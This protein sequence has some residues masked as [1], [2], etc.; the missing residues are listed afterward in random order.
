MILPFSSTII[1]D[2][3]A[4]CKSRQASIVYFYFDFRDAK[5][6]RLNDLISSIITQLSAHPDLRC[7]ILLRLY[8]DHD[9]GQRQPSDMDMTKCLKEMLILPH[10]PPIY[11]IIDAL[12]ESPDLSGIPT[13]REQVLDLVKELVDLCLPNLHICVTSRPEI[14][15]RRVIEPLT[16]L[17]VCLHEQSGQK[18]DIEEYIRS[19]VYSE[20][21]PIMRQWRTEDK[22]FV[23]E[24]L[25][26]KANGM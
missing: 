17:R 3:E 19:V 13:S 16:S 23:I 12:D 24:T 9:G 4:L 14:D 7:D 15:I 8:S 22:E 26:E 21:E 1:Q 18:K 20:S 5:K 2:I 25:S 6:Q 11:L 10:Q